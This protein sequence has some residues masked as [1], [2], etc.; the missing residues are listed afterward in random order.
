MVGYYLGSLGEL[1]LVG[2]ILASPTS[3]SPSPAST[4]NPFELVK[5][6]ASE[7]VFHGL[8]KPRGDAGFPFPCYQQVLEADFSQL[9]LP[10]NTA[11]VSRVW[12]SHCRF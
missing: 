9:A 11:C 4:N 7:A 10:A 6:S 3:G 8:L 1:D 2:H 5:A 12:E